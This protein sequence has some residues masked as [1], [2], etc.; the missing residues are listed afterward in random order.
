MAN[1]VSSFYQ[2]VVAA[3]AEASQLLAPTWKVSESI[4]WDYRPEQEVLGQTLNVAIPQDPTS[5]VVDQ[6]AGD[7]VLSD[8]GFS[9]TPIVFNRHPAYHYVVRD[10]EQ[11][12]SPTLLRRVFMDAAMKGIRNNINGAVAALFTASNFTTNTA[13]SCTAHAVT[14]TQFLQGMA[15]LSKQN[16]PVANDPE[17]MSFL[18]YPE[19]YTNL[20][21]TTT[22]TAGA[23]WVQAFIAGASTAEYVRGRGEMP[24]SYGMTM[25]LDQQMP[26]TAGSTSTGAYFHRWAVAGVTRPLP[27]P[28]SKVVEYTYVNFGNNPMYGGAYGDGSLTMPIRVMVGYN[29][30]PK[31]GYIVSVEAGYGLKVVRENMCQLFTIAY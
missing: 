14:V 4:Y 1:T 30:F 9:T 15:V 21:D 31:G 24:T 23:A 22:G 17:N 11:F 12:N 16:V 19:V 28:D 7:A 18:L 2:T 13:I 8:I 20:M 3:A 5:A 26:A 6:G 29:Q 27:E 10:F 25:K